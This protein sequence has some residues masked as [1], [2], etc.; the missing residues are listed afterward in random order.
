MFG[1]FFFFF[2]K[3]KKF[4]DVLHKGEN[5]ICIF[6]EH[7]VF[8]VNLHSHFLFTNSSSFNND[9]YFLKKKMI[10]IKLSLILK[11]KVLT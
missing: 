6:Y 4:Y 11:N 2:F 8:F 10:I 3:K 9:H 1:G 7:F 5:C